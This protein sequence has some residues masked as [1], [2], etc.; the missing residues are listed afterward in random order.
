MQPTGVL[1]VLQILK[2]MLKIN[3]VFFNVRSVENPLGCCGCFRESS[4]SHLLCSS[5]RREKG[6]D[7][8]EV[9][10]AQALASRS[11]EGFQKENL[12]RTKG[13]F[14]HMLR[15]LKGDGCSPWRR[16]HGLY[17]ASSRTG[18]LSEGEVKVHALCVGLRKIS[19]MYK[20]R[21]I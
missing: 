1:L 10:P 11:L 16:G 7:G 14:V 13:P 9:L 2:L 5:Q 20:N 18:A 12:H 3:G 21:I 8:G 4:L 6:A 19:N 15:F 17:L